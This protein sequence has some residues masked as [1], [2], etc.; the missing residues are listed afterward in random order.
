MALLKKPPVKRQ[1]VSRRVF[2]RPLPEPINGDRP[3]KPVI[4]V[5]W[6]KKV[7]KKIGRTAGR[8]I[9][10]PISVFA[11]KD[12][13]K[14]K[15]TFF[16]KGVLRTFDKGMNVA[17]KVS[18]AITASV[19]GAKLLKGAT[20]LKSG[21]NPPKGMSKFGSFFNKLVKDSGIKSALTSGLKS[22]AKSVLESTLSNFNTS[23]VVQ[24]IDNTSLLGI[25]D[26]KKARE[27]QQFILMVLGIAL[28]SIGLLVAIFKK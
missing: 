1:L 4:K 10:R 13:V 28:A 17:T 24:D 7:V 21:V 23:S 3:S 12:I 2:N 22:G 6:L 15:G 20:K 16:D 25:G 9:T 19:V 26:K 18:G 5:G 11:G 14:R 8:V 27:Q